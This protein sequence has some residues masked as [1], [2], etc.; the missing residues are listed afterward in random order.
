[1]HIDYNAKYVIFGINLI[2]KT[3]FIIYVDQSLH[4]M[5]QKLLKYGFWGVLVPNMWLMSLLWCHHVTIS[6]D[7]QIAISKL[8]T[9]CIHMSQQHIQHNTIM[10]YYSRTCSKWLISQTVLMVEI[11]TVISLKNLFKGL[12][13]KYVNYA[14]ELI[15]ILISMQNVICS[16]KFVIITLSSNLWIK[17]NIQW[18]RN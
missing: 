16:I 11:K 12:S 2:I 7:M 14:N 4:A 10:T 8:L 18:C 1:M 17:A 13:H 3:H 5:K 9:M 6:M 15:C